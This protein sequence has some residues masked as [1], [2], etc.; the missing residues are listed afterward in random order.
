MNSCDLS[1]GIFDNKKKHNVLTEQL[2]ST[3]DGE[4]P[5]FFN[6]ARNYSWLISF[7]F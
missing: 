7:R 6:E 2:Y 5:N 4:F 3:G 1:S